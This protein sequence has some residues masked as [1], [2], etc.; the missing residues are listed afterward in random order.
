MSMRN[1]RGRW[2]R[3]LAISMV[4]IVDIDDIDDI[5]DIDLYFVWVG[6]DIDRYNLFT[7][8]QT[9]IKRAGRVAHD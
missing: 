4:D 5:V 1:S 9:R 8:Y 6:A 7:D 2:S 3:V